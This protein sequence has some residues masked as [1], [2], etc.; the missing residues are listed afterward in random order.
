MEINYVN[1]N[2]DDKDIHD[3]IQDVVEDNIEWNTL[4][5]Y[6][7]ELDNERWAA[8]PAAADLGII[9]VGPTCFEALYDF[10]LKMQAA[11][12][13]SPMHSIPGL[14]NPNPKAFNGELRIN[15]RRLLS[16]PIDQE[17]NLTIDEEN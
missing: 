8:Y 13:N 4:D 9:G 5:V 1:T 14:K 15:A 16:I 17:L 2:K 6:V 10:K 12:L 3:V 11:Y 7:K